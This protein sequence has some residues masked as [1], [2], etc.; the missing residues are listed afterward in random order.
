MS[1][2]LKYLPGRLGNPD[3]LLK[4][5]KRLDPDLSSLRGSGH[6][7]SSGSI[8]GHVCVFL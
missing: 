4:V 5:D 3:S 7:R 6:G 2:L 8:T 1:E